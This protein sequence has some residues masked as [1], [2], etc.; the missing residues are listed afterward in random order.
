MTRILPLLPLLALLA[1]CGADGAPEAPTPTPGV[2]ITGE[3]RAGVVGK[4]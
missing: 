4:L 1:A 3:V 2:S